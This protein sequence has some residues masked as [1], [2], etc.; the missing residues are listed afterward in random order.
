ML[1]DYS[2]PLD[3]PIHD[4]YHPLPEGGTA[5]PDIARMATADAT[6]D[7][8]MPGTCGRTSDVLAERGVPKTVLGLPIGIEA[9]DAWIGALERVSGRPAIDW[10]GSERGRLLDAYADGHKYVYGKR[11]ALFGDPELVVAL[12]KFATEIGMRP[13]LCAT[14][15]RNRALS[16]GLE[17]LGA[18]AV[19]RVLE[20]TDFSTIET[21]AKELEV[22]LM[23]GNSKGYRVARNM[24][25]P[26]LRLGFP[27]HDRIGAGRI[28]CVGYRGTLGLFDSLVNLLLERVQDESKVGFSYL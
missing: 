9:T 8:T 15:A 6:L 5:I 16:Q 27:I 26:L 4:T 25:V 12:A 19:E 28:L 10:L 18:N 24:G 3:G 20:D 21:V 1:P 22:E 23:I 11:L 7:L 2:D 17:V 14:G 13:V